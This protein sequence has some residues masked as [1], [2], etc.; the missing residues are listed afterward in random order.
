MAAERSRVVFE[1]WLRRLPEI[2]RILVMVHFLSGPGSRPPSQSSDSMPDSHAIHRRSFD[3]VLAGTSLRELD[4]VLVTGGDGRVNQSFVGLFQRLDFMRWT[5][6]SA[7][8]SLES[9]RGLPGI[10]K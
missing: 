4:R 6:A 9:A 2:A 8:S 7:E 3:G 5:R 1:D 10:T